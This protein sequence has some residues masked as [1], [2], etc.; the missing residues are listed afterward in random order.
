MSVRTDIELL[1]VISAFGIVWFHSGLD[2]GRDIAYAGLIYFLIVASYFAAKSIKQRSIKQRASRLLIPCV[3]W[4]TV[5]A[6]FKLSLGWSLFKGGH[7]LISMVLTTPSIHLWFLPFLFFCLVAVDSIKRY[8]SIKTI[9]LLSAFGASTLLLTSSF[10]REVSFL[11][12]LAQYTHAF[13]AVLIGLFL[14]CYDELSV[15]NKTILFG[16]LCLAITLTAFS[17]LNGISI[18]YLIG[19]I[20]S[21]SLLCFKSLVGENKFIL[22]ISKLTFGIYLVHVLFIFILKHFDVDGVMLPVT[23]FILS[24]IFIHALTLLI[25]RAWLKY[26]I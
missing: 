20:A 18:T 13:P 23:V 7:S 24:A 10:W 1:R 4:S 22:A 6:S 21:L 2:Y 17:K 16:G 5:Y 19:F 3:L 9:A 26:V 15:R 25:P 11:T 8:L 12:P 14:G